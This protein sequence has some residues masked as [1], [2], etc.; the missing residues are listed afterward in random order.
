MIRFHLV[1]KLLSEVAMNTST[2]ADPDSGET[3]DCVATAVLGSIACSLATVPFWSAEATRHV[4]LP[5]VFI[6]P[7][8]ASV[9]VV[10]FLFCPRHRALPKL[11]TML[12]TIPSFYGAVN[13][14]VGYVFWRC[15]SLA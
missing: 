9:S 14:I 11:T 2:H 15:L 7:A 8:L 12:L 13:C 4:P 10:A 6:A 3:R 5:Y 1:F